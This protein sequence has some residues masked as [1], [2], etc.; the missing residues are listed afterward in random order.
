MSWL[1]LEICQKTVPP[2]PP[3]QSMFNGSAVAAALRGAPL[4]HRLT[5]S[6]APSSPRIQVQSATIRNNNI[7]S[8]LLCTLWPLNRYKFIKNLLSN[9]LV[10]GLGLG[11]VDWL[12]GGFI[13]F[14][15]L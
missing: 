1:K 2:P 4:D 8:S 13:A 3:T 15:D 5:L 14:S 6:D 10:M 11:M 7:Y 12:V 9:W